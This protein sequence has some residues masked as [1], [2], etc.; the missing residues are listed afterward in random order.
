MST[1]IYMVLPA[2]CFIC[3]V[4]SLWM[5]FGRVR[6]CS[7]RHMCIHICEHILVSQI[8]FYASWLSTSAKLGDVELLRTP[9]DLGHLWQIRGLWSKL[10]SH[11][12]I[13]LIEAKGFSRRTRQNTFC[14]ADGTCNHR[15]GIHRIRSSLLLAVSKTRQASLIAALEMENMG[16]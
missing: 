15:K 6:A 8:E 3:K 11:N 7:K 13:T 4:N 12:T 16:N 5:L 2:G 1:R 14:L 9:P 10:H